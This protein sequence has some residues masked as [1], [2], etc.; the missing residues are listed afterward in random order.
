MRWVG[1]PAGPRLL[2]QVGG[3]GGNPLFVI[4]LVRALHD[5]GAI[6]LVDGRAE[7]GPS[8]LPPSL[9]LT[10]VRRLSLLPEDTLNLLRIAS[11]LGATF[12]LTELGLLAGRSPAQLVPALAAAV[13][14]GL[15]T[16][17]GDQSDRP[18]TN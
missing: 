11:I 17:A 9:R 14:A 13:D 2:A 12:S 16:E 10:L 8:S 6:D 7:V 5:E 1:A 18:T 3:A 4:E 15:L